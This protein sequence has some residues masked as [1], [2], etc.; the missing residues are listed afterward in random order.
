MALLAI[1]V[2]VAPPLEDPSNLK[3]CGVTLRGITTETKVRPDT[4]VAPM[5]GVTVKPV[6]LVSKLRYL[7]P[8][9]LSMALVTSWPTGVL[10]EVPTI[11]SPGWVMSPRVC[12]KAESTTQQEERHCRECNEAL[13]FNERITHILCLVYK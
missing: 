8:R 1:K 7:V 4:I 2:Q 12:A 6:L 10:A 9:L 11:R 13:Q 3:L 5:L